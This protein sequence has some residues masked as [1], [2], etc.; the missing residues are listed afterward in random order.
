[1]RFARQTRT[2]LR[3]G[4]IASAFG[5][6]ASLA[7]FA[8]TA[9]VARAGSPYLEVPP[10]EEAEAS[11]AYHYAN[12]TNE[13][14]FAELDRRGVPYTKEPPT[15]GVRAPIRLA[16]RLHG[17]DIHS[18][19]SEEERKTTM[20]EILDAR[21][22]LAL[23][24][25]CVI[26]ARHDVIEV[27]HYTMYRPNVAPPA[28]PT[29]KAK[30]KPTPTEKAGPKTRG[31]DQPPSS[32]R[33]PIAADK[34]KPPKHKAKTTPAKRRASLDDKAQKEHS[35]RTGS[36]GDDHKD[37][38]LSDKTWLYAD[39]DV[40]SSDREKNGAPAKPATPKTSS[41]TKQHTKQRGSDAHASHSTKRAGK[42]AKKRIMMTTNEEPHSRWAPPGTRHPAGL[43]I[44]VGILKKVDGTYLNVAQHFHGKIGAKT[45]GA[46]VPEADTKEARELRS[47]VCEAHDSGIFTYALTPNFNADHA[48]HF[49]LEIKPGVKWFLYH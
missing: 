22:A 39:V 14:A 15:T 42:T 34:Q 31:K 36:D 24:D 44:D 46:D 3:R 33:T 49:H 43:A 7:T 27:V 13:E 4:L 21:L 12:M 23:D 10:P 35:R 20:F 9:G 8:S 6:L 47:I 38:E 37:V 18:S 5:I 41:H 30:G 16:G 45:C 25:F 32:K 29:T 17:V 1:V 28:A 11:P 2:A 48:D 26:L 19:L 40:Q